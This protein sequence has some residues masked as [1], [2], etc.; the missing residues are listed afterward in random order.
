MTKNKQTTQFKN[1]EIGKIPEEWELVSISQMGE[2]VTG[3]TPS[4]KKEEFYGGVYNLISPANLDNGK[5]VKDA[6]KKLTKKG[7]EE[8]RSLP[9][10]SIL[11]GCIGSVGKLGM[12][13]DDKSVTNQQIN[14]VICQK[15]F[16]SDFIYYLFLSSK[17]IFQ[18]RAVKTTVPILN[19]TRFSNI[20]LQTP[21]LQ[22]Q[23]KIAY[24][25]TAVQDAIQ[26]QEEIIEKTKELKKSLMHKLFTEGTRGEPQ[27]QTEIGK[28]PESWEIVKVK[29]A[30]IF[31]RKPR[32]LDLS[33][34]TTIPFLPMD[35]LSE[36]EMYPDY[37]EK[38]TPEEIKSGTYFEKGN[39][40]LAKI[41]PSF[42]NGKQC[43]ANIDNG[44]GYAT[45]EV[46]VIDDELEKTKIKYLYYLLKQGTIRDK[47]ADK[48]EGSTGRQRLPKEVLKNMRIPLPSYKEQE[49]II[50]VFESLDS[51]IRPRQEKKQKLEEL[52]KS[53]LHQLMRGKIRVNNLELEL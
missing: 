40:L 49:E 43:I 23:K 46:W 39:L 22:E 29:K 11:V 30:F 9:K 36:V 20:K 16:D 21:R 37:I 33:K 28:I 41:T 19:K 10:N 42:E 2:I 14:A 12:T 4:T 7:F 25:L 53:L 38:R 13:F 3:S 52:F 32:S 35:S 47:L 44:F 50:N 27:K 15:D 24:V 5:Y 31:P 8:A 6:H 1:T 51:K 17:K 48:M 18:Q 34:Q 45:T 26:K